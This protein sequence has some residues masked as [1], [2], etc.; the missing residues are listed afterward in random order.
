MGRQAHRV[1]GALVAALLL[2]TGCGSTHS[3]EELRRALAVPIA[4][5]GGT[6]QAAAPGAPAATASGAAPVEVPAAGSAAA[7]VAGPATI[8]VAAGAAAGTVAS[9]APKTPAGATATPA[10][11][12][13]STGA[14]TGAPAAATPAAPGGPA[15]AS[16]PAGAP[17]STLTLGSIG[18]ESGVLG[19][20]MRPI[21][22]A[23]KAWAGD[24]NARGGLAGHPVRL[25][26][27]DDTGDPGKALALVRRM[28]D[29]DGAVAFY[30]LHGLQTGQALG[31]FLEERRIPA[32]GMCSCTEGSAT[33]PMMFQVGTSTD[34]GLAWAHMLALTTLTPKRKLS[35]LYCRETPA[36]KNIR[37]GIVKFQGQAGITV[38]HE[39]QVTV[40][41][42]DYTAEI[43]AARNAGAEAIVMATDNASVIRGIRSAHRQNYNPTFVGQ[44]ATAEDRFLSVG[45]ADVEGTVIGA[46][47]VPWQSPRFSDY[48]AALD[49]YVPGAIK[50]N[51]GQVVWAGGKLMEVIAA[52]FGP[53]PTKDD[54]LAGLFAL[55]GETLGGMIPPLTYVEGKGSALT[56]VCT[57]P[58]LV[59]GGRFVAPGG[60]KFSCAPGWKPQEK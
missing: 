41:Q 52:R 33:S 43:L 19:N 31:S 56:N 28:V 59:T 5:S 8:P 45:G 16:T 30:A 40:T 26:F 22:E 21:F 48:V 12:A 38:V 47:L 18:T 44:V 55:R 46:S 36:C 2:A 37:D 11:P 32:I 51:L 39:A 4:A 20:L 50:G 54:F 25:L 49:R 29:Q 34:P 9:A 57:I 13:G 24:I 17:K 3:D 1:A 42:P 6:E 10:G 53:N 60:D 7:G 58:L 27:G 15:P 14:A 35:V 23:A